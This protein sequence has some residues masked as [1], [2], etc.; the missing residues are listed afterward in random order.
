MAEGKMKV[1]THFM[2]NV[3]FKSI[4]GDAAET[5]MNALAFLV[6]PGEGEGLVNM[7]SLRYIDRMRRQNDG[8]R[9]SYRVH[10]LD[11][12]CQAPANFATTLAQ[13]V[14]ALPAR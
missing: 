4:R 14:V 3:V 1:T 5:E 8:W 13:R 7:R 6:E 11:W 9:I 2:G 12:S 10:T